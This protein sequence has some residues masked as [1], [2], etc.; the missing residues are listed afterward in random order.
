MSSIAVIGTLKCFLPLVRWTGAVLLSGLMCTIAPLVFAQ[1]GAKKPDIR[2]VIDVSGSMKL[3]DPSNL[4]QPAV[5]LL[6]RL[7]PEG[8]KAGVWTF[9]MQVNMLVPHQ[10]VNDLW[11]KQAAGKASEI[12]SVGLFTNIGAALEK[13]SHDAAQGSRE[14]YDTSI[15]LLTDGMVDISKDPAANS[16]EWKRIVD[17]VLPKLKKAGYTVHTVALSDKADKELMEK[18][19]V[20]TD[21]IFAVAHTADD[22]MEIFLKAFSVAAPAQALPLQNNSFAVDSSVEEFTALIFRKQL[23]QQTQLIG[24]DEQTFSASKTSGGVKWFRSEN[25][26]LITVQQPLE[27][28]WKIVAELESSSR[29]TVVSDLE[30][31]VKKLPNNALRGAQAELSFLLEEEGKTVISPEFLGL[32]DIKATV[33]RS[34]DG[35]QEELVWS[36]AFAGKELPDNGI[37][38]GTVPGFDKLGNYTF[39]LLVDGKTFKRQFSHNLEVREPFSAELIESKNDSG[40]LQYAI[41]VRAHADEIPTASTQVAAT[42]VK[43]SKRNLIKPLIL[44]ENG[45]WQTPFYPDETGEYRINV[46]VTGTDAQNRSFSYDLEELRTSHNPDAAFVE[47]QVESK[48]EPEP[49]PEVETAPLAEQA[50]VAPEVAPEPVAETPP[51]ERPAWM[52]YAVLGLGNLIILSGGYLLFRKLMGG[53]EAEGEPAPEPTPTKASAKP[54]AKPAKV[55]EPEDEP[56]ESDAVM[57]PGDDDDEEPAMEDLDMVEGEALAADDLDDDLDD[58]RDEQLVEQVMGDATEEEKANFAEEVLK[59]Q[60]LELPEEELDDAISSLIDDLD[61]TRPEESDLPPSGF[62]DDEDWDK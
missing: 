11:R 13:A 46:Q 62:E 25:Y 29:I 44:T 14:D 42:I 31:R 2:L 32:L 53:G 8:G 23:D 17:E 57:D 30:L 28:E 26:D 36:H 37:F 51:A 1:D 41:K 52:L 47:P 24:P 55:Q 56:D 4:R 60:G 50:E 38:T 33:H 48:P 49:E 39:E 15:I 16:K 45:N 59:A 7:M 9:G 6:V 3:N 34:V 58:D 22:L 54:A 18:L 10:P 61:G 12:N 35:K 5:D 19:A 21:G 20:S 43:P 40:E 27:G